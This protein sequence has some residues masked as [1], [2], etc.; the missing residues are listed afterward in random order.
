VVHGCVCVCVCLS[1]GV[2]MQ[3]GRRSDRQT[4][5]YAAWRPHLLMTSNIS[6]SSSSGLVDMSATLY[7][8]QSSKKQYMALRLKLCAWSFRTLVKPVGPLASCTSSHSPSTT[9]AAGPPESV[10]ATSVILYKRHV[11]KMKGRC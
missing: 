4:Y 8:S 3:A 6:Q 9:T 2:N 5:T 10:G 7:A 1:E 11:T